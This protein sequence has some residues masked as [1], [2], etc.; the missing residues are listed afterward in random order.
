LAPFD[1]GRVCDQDEVAVIE[2]HVGDQSFGNF[3]ADED[4]NADV[5]F[6]THEQRATVYYGPFRG[7][8]PNDEES[9]LPATHFDADCQTGNSATT[10]LPGLYG[11]GTLAISV[12]L[13]WVAG[14]TAQHVWLVPK[15]RPEYRSYGSR[16]A[17]NSDTFSSPSQVYGDWNGDGYVDITA[18]NRIV[19]GPFLHDTNIADLPRAWDHDDVGFL[20]LG[21]LPDATG[22][23][24]PEQV[25][26]D[27]HG[28]YWVVPGQVDPT[29]SDLRR[30]GVQLDGAT[31]RDAQ[32][33]SPTSG[34]VGDFDGDG[35]GDL[36]GVDQRTDPYAI[37]VWYGVDLFPD[38]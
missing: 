18:N 32:N 35:K 9:P 26:V 22:D 30:Y 14:C 10:L 5:L 29:T 21:L 24:F 28:D 7:T 12:G 38:G 6:V 17:Y 2:R 23:G 36:M 37:V 20:L 27:E 25:L 1:Q 13:D 19:L 8:L 34:L 15:D 3:D 31:S 4:G 33:L 11:P 16:L